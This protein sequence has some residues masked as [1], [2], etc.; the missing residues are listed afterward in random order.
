MSDDGEERPCGWL[1]DRYGLSWQI[2]P[3]TLLELTADLD[4]ERRPGVR[5]DA[6]DGRWPPVCWPR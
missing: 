4:R 1:K 3:T 5:G 6:A 2:V